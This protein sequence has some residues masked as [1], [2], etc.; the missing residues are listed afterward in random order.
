[1]G[2]QCLRSWE[3]LRQPREYRRVF[4]YGKKLVAP[5][6]VLYVLPE[7]VPCSRLGMAVSKRVGKAVVRNRVKRHIR[8]VFRRHKERLHVPCDVVVVARRQASQASAV[9]FRRQ[10]LTLLHHYQNK[11]TSSAGGKMQRSM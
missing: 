6:F 11:R 9:D 1:M 10:F 8:E 4:Q 7:A 3:R 2:D 5:A